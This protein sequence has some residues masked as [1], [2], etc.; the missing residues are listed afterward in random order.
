MYRE[1]YQPTM[2]SIRYRDGPL[3]LL[4]V[5]GP[6]SRPRYP[7][8]YGRIWASGPSLGHVMIL[9]SGPWASGPSLGHVM[10]GKKRRRGG[11]LEAS[12]GPP[13]YETSR[14]ST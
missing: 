10:S 9:S 1:G 7:L 2:V 11:G 6:L 3:L 8:T 13:S 14:F 12:G 5:S 4:W